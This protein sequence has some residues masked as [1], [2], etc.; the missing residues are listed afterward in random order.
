MAKTNQNVQL[1]TQTT[2]LAVTEKNITDKVLA[3]V[4]QLEGDRGLQFPENYSYANA[5]KS[6]WLVLQ[7]VKDLSKKPALEVCT[8][9]SVANALLDMIVQGLTPAKKQCYFIVYGKELQLS[10]S[11]FGTVAVAKRVTDIEDVFSEVIYEGDQFEYEINRG[12]KKFLSHKQKMANIDVKKVIGA[13][14]ILDRGD[15]G[16]ELELMTIEQ[17][18]SAW[19]MGKGYGKSDVHK[20]F[21]DRMARKTVINRACTLH[22]GSSNDADVLIETINRVS[23]NDSLE[24]LTPAETATKE[25]AENA[26]VEVLDFDETIEQPATTDSGGLS[27]AEKAEIEANEKATSDEQ[28]TFDN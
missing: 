8:Q 24:A 6:A 28:L 10:R 1:A 12:K 2:A 4:K 14:A 5:L 23:E 16:E 20:T 25:I 17:I 19:A 11:Y 13:Y 15:K 3:K 21:S 7:N 9:V 18:K 22:I 26:N 27:E